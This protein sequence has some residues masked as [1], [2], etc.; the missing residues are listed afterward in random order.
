MKPPRPI[1]FSIYLMLLFAMSVAVES[2]LP[3]ALFGALFLLQH[4]TS[5]HPEGRVGRAMELPFGPIP[6]VGETLSDHLF[7]LSAM[8]LKYAIAA[9]AGAI[10][11]AFLWGAS[12]A[13]TT[14]AAGDIPVFQVLLFVLPIVFGM[15]ML[16]ALWCTTRAYW[17]ILSG[18]DQIFVEVTDDPED[19]RDR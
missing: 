5:R 9:L 15:G 16:A 1:F 3:A 11:V 14:P 19:A 4:F 12:A 2:Y 8:G 18:T 7:S 13:G 10:A 6:K 17:L